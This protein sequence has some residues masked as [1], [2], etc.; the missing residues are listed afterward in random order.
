MQQSKRIAINTLSSWIGMFANAAV[1]IFLT[2]FLLNR[3]GPVKFGMLRYVLTI[4]GSL[5]FL[6][7]GLGATLN[8]FVSQLLA[9][10]DVWQLNAKISFT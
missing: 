10:N 1:L 2:K 6:D 3:L 8:R 7:L 9:A 5:L 4:Q